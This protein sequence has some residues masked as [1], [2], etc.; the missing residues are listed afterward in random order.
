MSNYYIYQDQ[1]RCIGCHACEVHCKTE[2]E[3]PIG[4]RYVRIIPVGP[5]MINNVPRVR[6]VFMPCF[7]CE[8]PWCVSACPTG[9]M[10][11]RDRDGIVFVDESL[12]VG[13]KSCITA[14]PWGVPQWDQAKGKVQKCNYCKDRVDEGLQPACVTGCTTGALRWV[15]PEEASQLKREQFARETSENL[16]Y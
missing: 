14:C 8:K 9:A 16:P 15:T 3:V 10:Q 6:F 12:C 11:K 2:N 4:M 5:K 13:C 1:K 7:H